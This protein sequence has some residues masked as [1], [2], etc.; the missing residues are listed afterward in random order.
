MNA[1]EKK[2]VHLVQ[3]HYQIHG[4]HDLPWRKTN[5]PYKIIVSEVMLQQTQVERVL[6]KY[7][8][9]IRKWPTARA[10]TRAS[11]PQVL[12][13]WQ[14]LGYNRRAKLLHECAKI[15]T[16]EHDGKWPQTHIE[17]TRLPGIGSY[18]AGAVMAFA[19]NQPV[20]IIETNI[21]TV[22]LHHFF[23]NQ[24]N[25]SEATLMQ[26]ITKTLDTKHPR[27][28]YW[29]L[30][31]YGSF[32]KKNE[33]YHNQR[34]KSYT[35]QSTFKGSD[36]EIRGAILRELTF[37]AKTLAALQKLAFD[38]CRVETQVHKLLTEGMVAKS[39]R[40]YILPS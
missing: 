10:L 16:N 40:S 21:R 28:W 23:K 4:R 24:S 26:V 32:L 33:G 9:F 14:G 35:K 19:F 17:F 20:P 27:E 25:V 2:F 37:G 29:A 18:T 22:Y 38:P 6:P 31:D 39:N 15:I 34:A 11:P 7:N 13:A 3:A 30:M 12:R 8:E 1:R 36:R 5:D